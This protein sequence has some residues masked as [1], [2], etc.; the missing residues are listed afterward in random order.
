VRVSERDVNVSGGFQRCRIAIRILFGLGLKELIAQKVY[1]VEMNIRYDRDMDALRVQ[2]REG[3]VFESDEHSPG[4]ILD[5]DE[6]GNLLAVEILDA[7]TILEDPTSIH[8]SIL[9]PVNT[10]DTL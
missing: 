1:G 7:S 10:P 3:G 8:F 2:L 4:V 6:T 9:P 5:Y